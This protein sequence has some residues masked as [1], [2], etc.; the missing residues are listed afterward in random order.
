[1]NCLYFS[2]DRIRNGIKKLQKAKQGSTQGRLDSFFS[3]VSTSSTK[4][5]VS[6]VYN[7]NVHTYPDQSTCNEI[8]YNIQTS[9]LV[10]KFF[11]ILY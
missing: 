11:I 7:T 10:M 8:C 1:M 5:K 6:F 3:V 2:E 4:R 9:L